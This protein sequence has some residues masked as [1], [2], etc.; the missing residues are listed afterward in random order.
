M[1]TPEGAKCSGRDAVR[2]ARMQA[3][4]VPG[5][6][7]ATR[8]VQRR[9]RR[10][11]PPAAAVPAFAHS[12][13]LLTRTEETPIRRVRAMVLRKVSLDHRKLKGPRR[14]HARTTYRCPIWIGFSLRG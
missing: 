13:L 14:Q 2:L 1:V 9:V 6:R 12:R 10:R 11:R 8:R 3:T 4:S 5:Q 7:T